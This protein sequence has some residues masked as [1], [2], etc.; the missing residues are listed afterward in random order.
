MAIVILTRKTDLPKKGGLLHLVAGSFSYE[1]NPEGGTRVWQG[2]S[3]FQYAERCPPDGTMD[4]GICDDHV[5]VV[6]EPVDVITG[7]LHNAG[8][9]TYSGP[10]LPLGLA[11]V[12]AQAGTAPRLV[13][14]PEEERD[15]DTYLAAERFRRYL[16]DLG[17]PDRFL[18]SALWSLLFGTSPEVG[19]RGT[20]VTK[21][22][23]IQRYL[24]QWEGPQGAW[25]RGI[26][27]Y[28]ATDPYSFRLVRCRFN[29]VPESEASKSETQS[30]KPALV[31]FTFE[32]KSADPFA[33]ANWVTFQSALT[34]TKGVNAERELFALVTK[35]RTPL[36]GFEVTY[37]SAA[38][39]DS[40]VCL[41][42]EYTDSTEGWQASGSLI[43]VG[44][45]ADDAQLVLAECKF[46]GSG[47]LWR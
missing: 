47:N 11:Q 17:A 2:P 32:V 35:C 41:A 30:D 31:G 44:H 26:L 4:A 36:A 40:Y 9:K 39:D 28:V 14:V 25:A 37:R 15:R 20:W 12:E 24:W 3:A 33:E 13:V 34:R 43:A 38:D 6:E 29:S 45:G 42:W 7:L 23:N 22:P 1:P 18:D 21:T 46:Y 27:V 16:R 5:W 19:F 10:A 8:V